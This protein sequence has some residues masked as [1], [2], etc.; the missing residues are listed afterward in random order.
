MKPEHRPDHDLRCPQRAERRYRANVRRTN[1][2]VAVACAVVLPCLLVCLGCASDP[3][4]AVRANADKQSSE[5]QE[6]SVQ[7]PTSEQPAS[8]AISDGGAD[9]R[10]VTRLDLDTYIA[11]F[12][13]T[14]AWHYGERT[15]GELAGTWTA[16]DGDGHRIMFGADGSFSEDFNGN[17]T[18]GLYAISENGRIVAFSKWNGIR[19]GAHYTLDGD[20]IVG[21]KGPQPKAKWSRTAPCHN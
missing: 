4:P 17:L 15:P 7:N 20:L 1:R 14:S 12:K 5:R 2:C 19:L 3:P 9:T 16:V 8:E 21:P 13:D 10:P 6:K 11:R 18:T